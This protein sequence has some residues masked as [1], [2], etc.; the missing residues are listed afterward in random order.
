ML[1]P[2][3][4]TIPPIDADAP[5]HVETATFALGCFWGPEAQ[6]G[7]VPGVIR[8]RVGYAGGT[9]PDPT[10]HNLGD[11]AETVQL[12]FDPA[13]ISYKKLLRFFWG[14]HVPVRPPR[15]RQ[16]MS[17]VW[18]HDDAQR[19]AAETIKAREE[20]R[21][22]HALFTEIAPLDTF[23]W[24]ED[25]HQKYSL[26]KFPELVAEYGAIYPG[27]EDFVNSTAVSRLN[28]FAAGYGDAATLEAE[29][30]LY[31]LSPQGRDIVL[32]IAGQPS[33]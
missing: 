2:H 25:Y 12:D 9:K 16:Y 24:A 30:D 7:V 10:Y 20:E 29:L 18:V 5:E 3:N 28:G 11:H 15:S 19:A 22:H 21:R 4:T 8:T 32:H 1:R 26:R 14:N 31:G 13:V 6:F 17:A 27:L 33:R 23:Y